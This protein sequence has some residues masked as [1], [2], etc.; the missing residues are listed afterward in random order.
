MGTG[1][2]AP[3]GASKLA[4]MLALSTGVCACAGSAAA[5][6]EAAGPRRPS[7][8]TVGEV[9]VTAER[10]TQSLIDVPASIS[11]IGST[12]LAERAIQSTQDLESQVPGLRV[13]SQAGTT[14]VAIRG[15][16]LSILY[17][18]AQPSIAQ[19]IDG[20]Y[21]SRPTFG[22]L[23]TADL[24]RV[25]V[26]RGPQ[27]TLYG[28]NASGGAINYITNAPTNTFEGRAE[29][30]YATYDQVRAEAV[31]SG[32]INDRLRGRAVVLY[33]D[34]QDGFQD[35]LLPGASEVDPTRSFAGRARLSYDV[36]DTATLDV[37]AYAAT[38]RGGEYGQNTAAIPPSYIVGNPSLD[39]GINSLEP[40]KL[41]I[42]TGRFVR[43][44]TGL[45]VTLRVK[46]GPGELKSISSFD[47]NRLRTGFDIDSTSVD[48]IYLNRF[49]R[50]K[51]FSQELSYS[52]NIGATDL[53]VGAYYAHD[54]LFGALNDQ[55]NG[56][57]N[58]GT[59]LLHPGGWLD[60]YYFP[61][62]QSY[63]AFVDINQ[64]VT[65]R[66]KLIAGI[67]YSK[68][69]I[70]FRQSG[71]FRGGLT[72]LPLTSPP[73]VIGGLDTCVDKHTSISFDAITPRL[74]AQY[75]LAERQNLYAT[76]SKGYKPGGVDWTSCGSTFDSEKLTSWE[77]GYKARFFDGRMTFNLSGFY[78]D[79]RNYQI[80]QTTGL[81]ALES[82]APKAT[83][84]GFEA[85]AAFDVTDNLRLDGSVAGLKARWRQFSDSDT[86][87]P[88][89]VLQNLKGQ[90]LPFSP[91]WSGQVGVQYRE[92]FSLGGHILVRAE[93]YRSS[94][95][96]FRQFGNKAD[97]QP[98]YGIF[99]A[100]ATW[101]DPSDRYYARLWAKNLADKDY[102]VTMNSIAP[103]G[104]RQVT[105]GPRRQVGLDLGVKF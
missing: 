75:E 101:N 45:A 34:R 14:Q 61:T 67:R 17:G 13:G 54:Q 102:F 62:Q 4:I 7:G 78:Y 79:Y 105:W 103:T 71:D 36:S 40:H 92:D 8:G 56:G 35:N 98:A 30:G 42:Q 28:R 5:Q 99:N 33:S 70:K 10:R 51:V 15:I 66:L 3:L 95:V 77:A 21:L 46:A 84:K 39:G 100:Y 96:N 44:A 18:P 6:V 104:N 49:E 89:P 50:S 59:F 82:N 63:A 29:V 97:S 38:G 2:Q 64:H 76:W 47:R 25:E 31:V 26:L 94:R 73:T 85:D 55:F 12:T 93:Y 57:F 1:L 80:Y 69:D 68:D 60:Y 20:V 72:L 16:G 37:S 90:P 83:V 32:P 65:P 91:D 86:L 48:A 53:V 58:A 52:A 24:A 41:A 27:G 22:D 9:V 87:E 88:T 23:A 19:Y 81:I 11:A 74:G 43:D